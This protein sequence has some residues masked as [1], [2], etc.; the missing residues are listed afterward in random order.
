[1]ATGEPAFPLELTAL[2]PPGNAPWQANVLE[3]HADC[4]RPGMQGRGATGAGR[5]RRWHAMAVDPGHKQMNGGSMAGARIEP[6]L[7]GHRG[8]PAGVGDGRVEGVVR[9]VPILLKRARGEI[10][11]SAVVPDV[12]EL[13]VV[14]LRRGRE[15]GDR[16]PH[17]PVEPHEEPPRRLDI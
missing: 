12:A 4:Q 1:S 13:G 14:V 6:S 10:E 17:A 5:A 11:S 8:Q 15:G 2:P 3:E 16:Y 7:I 9:V